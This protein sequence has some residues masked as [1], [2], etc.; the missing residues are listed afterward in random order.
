[1]T[2]DKLIEACRKRAA[3]NY[4]EYNIFVE[5]YDI[6]DWNTILSDADT[7]EEAF[8]IMDNLVEIWEDRI[9]DA[10]NSEF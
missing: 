3:A 4:V 6:A 1:M 10:K 7:V 5:C 8:G 9:F 2:K